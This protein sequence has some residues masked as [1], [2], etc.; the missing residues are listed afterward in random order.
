MARAIWT[1]TISFGLVNVPVKL[2]KAIDQKDIRF[3]QLD[4]KSG[5]RVRNKRVSEKS[6]REVPYERIVKGYEVDK[7]TFIPV[8][9]EELES[10]E[11]Q[12]QNVIDVEDIV[13]LSDIDPMQFV[14]TYWL[15]PADD[16]GAAKAYALLTKALER[17]E[18]V[19]VG[20]F[21]LRTKEHL[22]AIRAVDGA[23]A[24]HTMLFPDEVVSTK[25]VA[26]LPVKARPSKRELEM[27]EDLVS[28]LTTEWD[29]SRYRDRYRKRVRDLIERKAEG[30][31]IVVTEPEPEEAEVVD[32][33][34]ML[35][36][37]LEGT[38]GKRRSKRR[39]SA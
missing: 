8:T 11:P 31:E 28:A 32:L 2:Y 10:V 25:D 39:R 37:S 7:G 19:A 34:A 4:E 29:P 35:E 26:G 33:M 12:R 21:V 27:A 1:G 36:K 22:V 20:R 23:L 9:R 17:A 38:R 13:E 14:R 15:A 24:L 5:A 3:H 30:D 16:A 18:R 6:G